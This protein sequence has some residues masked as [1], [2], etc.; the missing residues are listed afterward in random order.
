MP[1]LL[2]RDNA[3]SKLFTRRLAILAGGQLTLFGLLIGRM[4]YLQVIESERYKVLADENRINLRLL[5]P[6][7]GRI[8]DRYG[9]PLAINRLNYRIV[10]IP[11]QT[12]SV[13]MTLDVLSEIVPIGDND[14]RRILREV[15]RKRRFLP[16]TVRDNLSWD[17]VSRVAVNTPDLPGVMI[18][19]GSTRA[20]P[21]AA[22]LSHILGYV[23]PPSEADLTGDPLLELP[24][25]RVG[26]N[27]VERIYDLALRG[28]AGT[29]QIEVNALGRPIRELA[30]NEGEPGH[31]LVLTLDLNLQR[32]AA[33]RL[34]REEKSVVPGLPPEERSGAAVL[35][36]VA[37]GD[38]LAL[39]SVPGY[40]PNEFNKGIS[41][42]LWR[43]LLSNSRTPLTNKAI[44]G[45]YPPGS[46]FKMMVAM[47]AL[48]AGLATPELRVSCPGFLEFGDNKFHCWKKGGHGALDMVEAIKQSCDVY[49]YEVARRIG[50]DRITQMSRRFGLGH[51]LGLDLPGERA[52]LMPTREWK[53]ATTGVT[54]QQGE[55]LVAGIGQGYVLATPLQLAV[56]TARIANGGFAVTP[57]L[58]RDLIAGR[59]LAARPAV[60]FPPVGVSQQA[61]AIAAR[62][63]RGVVNDPRGTAYGARIVDATMA[64]AGKTG[65]S[66]VRR[67]TAEERRVGLRKPSQVPW[68][69]RD[70]ALFVGYAP[71]DNPRYAVAVVVEHGGG[72]SAVAAP[73]ARD[74]LRA[75]QLRERE[76]P[77]PLLRVAEQPPDRRS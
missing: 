66:Q 53:L 39:V 4:Y 40:D 45:Q 20:Y 34:A 58:T 43:S 2:H 62:G 29:S 6:P 11:E 54:W 69:E 15:A 30:R 17:E 14:R 37:N 27:G 61:L 7:R 12:G 35:I 25:F 77:E 70:H 67:I 13:P 9:E 32:F 71:V 55:S 5:P 23:A 1:S 28:R 47:A 50:I 24:D 8:I 68:K 26:R 59:R 22:E 44:S 52:G 75:A 65:T 3:R 42:P 63:M 41:G 49:F 31:D 46:T 18:D 73:V 38:I 36:D 51:T 64:M 74:I 10:V 21:Y 76:R 48:E 33:E 16:V 19:V 72:G 56:M 57:H 60:S